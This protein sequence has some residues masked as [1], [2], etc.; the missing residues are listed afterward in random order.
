MAVKKTL[1]A[2][3]LEALGAER[4]AELLI[5]IS[6]GNATAKRRLRL[7]LAGAQ[8]PAEVGREIR[9]CLSAIARSRTFVDW[10][11]RRALVDD[12][13]APVNPNRDGTS[14]RRLSPSFGKWMC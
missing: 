5:E 3:N 7:E 12:L 10:Q 6:A 9:K 1:N 11:N 8:S 14:L 13:L 2:K 4:L